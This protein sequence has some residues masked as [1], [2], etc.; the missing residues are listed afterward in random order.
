MQDTE[1]LMVL[2]LRLPCGALALPYSR[3]YPE[4]GATYHVPVSHPDTL[5]LGITLAVLV[6]EL[7][8]IF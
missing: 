7:S 4:A 5:C 8:V 2:A 1:W 6:S 3:Q